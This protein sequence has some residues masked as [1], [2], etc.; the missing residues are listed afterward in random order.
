[1]AM[2]IAFVSLVFACSV[3]SALAAGAA[4]RWTAALAAGTT[5][6]GVV[7]SALYPHYVRVEPLQ[8]ATDMIFLIG[9]VILAM[10]YRRWWLIWMAAFQANGTASHFAALLSPV[11]LRLVYYVLSTAWGIPILWVWVAGICRD[12]G[13]TMSPVR[14]CAHM[15]GALF[16]RPTT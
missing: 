4:G 3:F 2:V 16:R 6:M 10:V 8:I 12:R 9:L 11:H 5:A 1:M 7:V 15:I 14:H 13:W